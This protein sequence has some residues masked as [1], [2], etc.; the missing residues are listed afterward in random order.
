MEINWKWNGNEIKIN[1][2]GMKIKWKWNGN[3]IK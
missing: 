1:G 3:E 2:S